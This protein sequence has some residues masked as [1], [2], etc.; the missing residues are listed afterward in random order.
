MNRVFEIAQITYNERF[1][2]AYSRTT[3]PSIENVT[4]K[5]RA[6]D[7][8]TKKTSKNKNVLASFD[9]KRVVED[10][11]DLGVDADSQEVLSQ[12]VHENEVR[13]ISL[14]FN[15][16]GLTLPMLTPLGDYF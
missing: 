12:Q 13:M 5:K 14:V 8:L 4:K 2:L 9:S 3:K 6:S 10:E 7:Q 11:V 15:S 16:S 1:P